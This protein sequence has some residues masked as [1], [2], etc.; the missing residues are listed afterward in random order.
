MKNEMINFR[1]LYVN[2]GM[3]DIINIEKDVNSIGEIKGM[4]SHIKDVYS[5]HYEQI[6][7]E[8]ADECFLIWGLPTD[9]IKKIC[10][11]ELADGEIIVPKRSPLSEKEYIEGKYTVWDYRPYETDTEIICEGKP[12]NSESIKL[13]VVYSYDS[14]KLMFPYDYYLTDY[15]TI[16]KL[17]KNDILSTSEYTNEIAVLICDDYSNVDEIKHCMENRGFLVSEKQKINSN[18]L[19]IYT[20]V[21]IILSIVM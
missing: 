9:E 18:T 12:L 16:E 14:D 15:K 8:S 17:K 6:I 4:N 19:K 1:T 13:D 11:R 5:V 20:G 7:V 21:C 10:N 3:A 2:V